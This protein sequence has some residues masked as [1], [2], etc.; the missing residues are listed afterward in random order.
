MREA[1]A[2]NLCIFRG[3]NI[4]AAETAKGVPLNLDSHMKTDALEIII[5]TLL[6]KPE[7]T[8]GRRASDEKGRPLQPWTLPYPVL[9]HL[10]EGR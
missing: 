10:Q 8:I 5:R 4:T 3:I 6:C 1:L 2:E 7:A 9:S